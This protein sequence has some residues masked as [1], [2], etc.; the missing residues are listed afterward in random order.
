M[1]CNHANPAG[2][3]FCATCGSALDRP[4]CLCG[5]AAS[6]GDAFCGR[7]GAPL[8]A[9][10]AAGEARPMTDAD[11][12]FDLLHLAEL[13]EQEKK[14]METTHKVRVTQDDI[15]KLLASRRKRF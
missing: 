12:R 10:G 5:F 13:A 2:Y 8:S 15:R 7:C 11:H 4:R 1:S 14:Y 3:A 9:S 6:P